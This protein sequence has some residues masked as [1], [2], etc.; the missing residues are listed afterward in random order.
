[1]VSE[2]VDIRRLRVL[3]YATNVLTDLSFRQI[4]GRVIRTDAGNP[5][6]SGLVVLPADPRLVAIA[7]AIRDERQHGSPLQ[8]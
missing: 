3:V 4:I 7:E 2:G 1:M 6:D 8:S 5:D